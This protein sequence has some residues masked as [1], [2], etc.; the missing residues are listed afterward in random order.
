MVDPGEADPQHLPRRLLSRT[1]LVSSAVQVLGSAG[2]EEWARRSTRNSSSWLGRRPSGPFSSSSITTTPTC[3]W[4]R[5]RRSTRCSAR[6]GAEDE[7]KGRADVG[8][9]LCGRKPTRELLRCATRP[10]DATIAYLDQQFEELLGELDKRGELR[11]DGRRHHV[12]SR[13]LF[14]EKGATGHGDDLHRPALEVPL[15][16][17]YPRKLPRGRRVEPRFR[18]RCL[19]DHAVA[20]RNATEA[21]HPRAAR[22]SATGGDRRLP[23]RP[24][25]THW[26]WS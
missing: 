22:W 13:R 23:G 12:R 2:T 11:T 19:G 16:V 14:G 5:W 4:C 18:S 15:L 6:R 17:S 20:R 1:E 21:A 8:G 24:G 3:R 25:A 26:S 10:Y 9:Q 7:S